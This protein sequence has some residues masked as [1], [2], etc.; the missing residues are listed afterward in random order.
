MRANPSYKE[1]HL[2]HGGSNARLFKTWTNMKTRCLNPV[3]KAYKWYGGRGI[4]I[5]ESWVNSFEN[6][7][8]WANA[9]GYDDSLTIDR[10]D[11]NGN[12]CPEN[13]RWISIQDQQRNRRKKCS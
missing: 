7:R 11:P 2:I 10:I 3:S 1:L 13:C 9:S 12:Y 6:F 4:L 8:N 5:C